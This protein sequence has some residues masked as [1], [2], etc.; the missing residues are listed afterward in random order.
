[1]EKIFFGCGKVWVMLILLFISGCTKEVEQITSPYEG[2]EFRPDS[3][4]HITGEESGERGAMER[5]QAFMCV[6][7]MNNE[8]VIYYEF[9]AE[10]FPFWNPFSISL[11]GEWKLVFLIN[12][13]MIYDRNFKLSDNKGELIDEMISKGRFKFKAVRTVFNGETLI[14]NVE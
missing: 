8:L 7:D 2:M 13:N 4:L 10:D 6:Y 5:V 9:I 3:L 1:M 12:S 14:L 11:V